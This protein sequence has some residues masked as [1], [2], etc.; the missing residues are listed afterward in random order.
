MSSSTL[1]L[2]LFGPDQKNI[3]QGENFL[4][5]K[6]SDLTCYERNGKMEGAVAELVKVLLLG[7]KIKVL[8][9]FPVRHRRK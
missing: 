9:S 3:R 5:G 6:K 8:G 1:N 7:G 2:I 4:V